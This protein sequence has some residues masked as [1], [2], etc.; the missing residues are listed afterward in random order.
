MKTDVLDTE[1]WGWHAEN[2]ADTVQVTFYFLLISR[3]LNIFCISEYI[4]TDIAYSLPLNEDCTAT[5]MSA[6]NIFYWYK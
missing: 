2:K 5:V 1:I 4:Y 6:F 3:R